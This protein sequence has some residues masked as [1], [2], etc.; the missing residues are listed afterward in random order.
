M[1]VFFL[2]VT[3]LHFPSYLSLQ[4][5]LSLSVWP[6]CHNLCI[7]LP[8]PPLQSR[9]QEASLITSLG[10]AA[11][12]WKLQSSELLTEVA[13]PLP[14]FMLLNLQTNSQSAVFVLCL[15]K[16]LIYWHSFLL[17]A[18]FFPQSLFIPQVLQSI[19]FFLFFPATPSSSPISSSFSP[20][21][22]SFILISFVC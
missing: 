16:I 19:N 14:S 20:S 2:T 9:L 17:F 13:P 4:H 6:P 18:V 21:L 11:N 10:S 8:F 22:S 12:F 5:F 3:V 15:S 1:M 7:F